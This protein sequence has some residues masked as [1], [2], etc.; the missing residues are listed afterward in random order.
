MDEPDLSSW[1]FFGFIGRGDVQFFEL[2]IIHGGGCGGQQAAGLL[3]FGE[4]DDIAD[5][6]FSC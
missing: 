5:R 2:L 6:V 3:G 1:L 4:A